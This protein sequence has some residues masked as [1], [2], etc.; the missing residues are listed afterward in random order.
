M[1]KLSGKLKVFSI[2]LIVLGALGIAYGFMSTPQ[3]TEDVKE[4]VAAQQAKNK[5]MHLKHDAEVDQLHRSGFAKKAM[6]S[7]EGADQATQESKLN[8]ALHQLQA[9]PYAAT[10]TAAF[11]FFMIALGVLVFQA[12]QY[13]AEAG[14]PRLLFRVFEGIHSYVLPGSIIVAILVLLA[15]THFYPWMDADLV[16]EDE[17]LQVK[18]LYL[19]MP[20][21]IIR[22]VIY[23]AIWNGYRYF[24][25]KNS[26]AQSDM[27]D[28]T[29]TRKNYNISVFFV[30]LF[31]LS[32]STMVWDWFMSMQPHW[33]SAMY[34]WYIFAG[35]FVSGLT[36]IA[37][38]TFYL[39]QKGHLDF[40]NDSHIH[41]LAKYIFAFSIFWTYLWFS[42]FML[43][44]YANIPEEAAYFV[45]RMQHYR[46][47]FL[48]TLLFNFVFPIL[49]LMNSD[50]KRIPWFISLVGVFILIGHYIDVYIMVIPSTMGVYG[51]FGIPEIAGI[52]FFLGLF[53]LIVGTALGKVELR[54]KGD[55]YIK[56]SENF[57]Y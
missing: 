16:A 10:F 11:F 39:K 52:L 46:L 44:W 35:L 30:I 31:G 43:I 24:M 8:K 33:F 40:I 22:M 17:I 23:L 12:I 26:L 4:I 29:Y 7:S 18:S 3:S 55:P 56:E 53:I 50:F 42:Q 34:A 6:Q 27:A 57:E 5:E 49:I 19:N 9:R 41:D 28:Y 45:L 48:I 20:G 36:V 15:G 38:I 21:F 54:P 14:W 47:P 13:I 51:A 32:E 2:I 25:T 1:F 37:L